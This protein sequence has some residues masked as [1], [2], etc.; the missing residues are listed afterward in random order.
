MIGAATGAGYMGMRPVI[1]MRGADF[2]ANAH[3]MLTTC[4]AS[5]RQLGLPCRMV[6]RV[7]AD[8]HG[9]RPP[10]ARGPEAG[11]LQ[12]PG[13]TVV[14]P[15]TASDAKGLLKS[16]IRDDDCVLFLEHADLYHRIAAVMPTGDHLVP[17]GSARV[18]RDGGDVTIITF[19]AALWKALDAAAE[20]AVAGVAAEVL[21]LR[22]LAPL[23]DATVFTSVRK[24][25]RALVV[26]DDRRTG[27][28]AGE[29]TA[30]ISEHCFEWLDAPVL[31]I[32]AP[33]LPL[34]FSPAHVDGLPPQVPDIVMAVKRLVAY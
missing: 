10:F 34:P 1:E 21:D 19:G 16:A 6:V 22:T 30:R 29:I 14:A 8:V 3:S 7:L 18:A 26:H 11:L 31:R 23:D 5:A 15:A 24:T 2:A 33:D 25:H 32:T 4:V 28:L 9:G 20:L 27:G 12:V 13:L 17:I